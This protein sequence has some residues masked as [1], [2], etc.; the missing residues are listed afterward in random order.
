MV[1][2]YAKEKRQ[3]INLHQTFLYQLLKSKV[4]N[5]EKSN[6][7]LA[8]LISLAAKARKTYHYLN[9]DEQNKTDDVS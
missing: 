2:H 4:P 3:K 1:C 5:K 7:W 8:T 6:Q 9:D